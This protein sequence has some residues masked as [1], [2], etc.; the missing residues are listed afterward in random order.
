MS[1]HQREVS[2]SHMTGDTKV[3]QFWSVKKKKITVSG[4]AGL[5]A[6]CHTQ[7]HST[8]LCMPALF[9]IASQCF[10][11]VSKTELTAR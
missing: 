10:R 3:V 2:D 11:R 4:N 9:A 7:K 1:S 5:F 6:S 8:L